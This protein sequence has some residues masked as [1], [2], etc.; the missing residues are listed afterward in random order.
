MLVLVL[1][2]NKSSIVLGWEKSIF[3]WFLIKSDTALL[4]LT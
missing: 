1:L 3:Q 4:N 2:V